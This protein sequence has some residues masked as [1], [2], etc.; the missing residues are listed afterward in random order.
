MST[1]ILLLAVLLSDGNPMVTVR[2]DHSQQGKPQ[3]LLAYQAA[4]SVAGSLGDA[5]AS[6]LSFEKAGGGKPTWTVFPADTDGDGT[7]E[8]IV[9]RTQQIKSVT[10][11]RVRVYE[12][13]LY[14]NADTGGPVATSK[15]KTAVAAN[16]EGFGVVIGAGDFR[17]GEKDEALLIREWSDGTQSLE[18]RRFPKKKNDRQM[19][20]VIASD[21]DFG[22][23]TTEW[24]IAACGADVDGD[25]K[26][27]IAVIRTNTGGTHSLL[28]FAP[29]SGLDGDTGAP[30]ASDVDITPAGGGTNLGIARADMDGDEVDEL[31]LL[32]TYP[33]LGQAVEL[34][35]FPAG[36]GGEIG[37]PLFIDG[38]LAGANE[39]IAA[40]FGLDGYRASPPKPPWD[41]SGNYTA[42]M[43]HDANGNSEL[44]P[45]L[46]NLVSP[47]TSTGTFVL[48][49]PTFNPLSGAYSRNAA[50]IDFGGGSWKLK[51]VSTGDVYWLTYSL[52]SVVMRNGKVV[53][54]GTYSG[55]K[56]PQSGPNQTI[57][58]GSFKFKRK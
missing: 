29:P 6:D 50:A 53:I 55:I 54:E 58:N 42:V 33:G 12:P 26:D 32:R 41:L 52:A 38:A 31:V 4:G 8:V 43:S 56:D 25:G 16:G 49:M 5:V 22:S 20:K 10:D 11:L 23:R 51:V 15:K 39:S 27:E 7:D 21:P 45:S 13:P 1:L 40:V 57:S 37:T 48:H 30:L 28:V 35:R 18:I 19:K 36:V 24:N 46:G 2:V 44:M 3:A 14:W 34:F 47:K 17:G 9:V